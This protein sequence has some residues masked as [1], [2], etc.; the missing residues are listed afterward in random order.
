ML[1]SRFDGEPHRTLGR[2]HEIAFE[3]AGVFDDLRLV[4]GHVYCPEP[5][6]KR[7]HW[8]LVDLDGAIVDPTAGQFTCGIDRY[9][10][11]ADGDPVRLGACMN[12]GEDIWGPPGPRPTFC[13]GVCEATYVA[14]MRGG[15]AT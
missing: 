2:C 8:W 10:E 7:G 14:Y 15:I 6:G 9:E 12:C 4:T 11:Y 1:V 3:M 13:G 5:W